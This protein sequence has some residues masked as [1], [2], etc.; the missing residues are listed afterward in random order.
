MSSNRM[1]IEWRAASVQRH[2]QTNSITTAQ[3]WH[4]S[5]YGSPERSEDS[6]RRWHD[7]FI[8]FGTVADRQRSGR[9]PI[10]LDEVREI[11]NSFNENPQLPTRNAETEP[12][13]PKSTIPDVVR[14]KLIMFPYK[15]SFLQELLPISYVGRLNWARYFHREIK[16]DTQ[17]LSRI[18]F[19]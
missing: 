8:R 6:I 2:I 18:F 17:Y 1:S 10:S 3:K 5:T 11:E 13:I 15:I 19:G 14:E 7:Y 12:R 16:R 4:R 9:P